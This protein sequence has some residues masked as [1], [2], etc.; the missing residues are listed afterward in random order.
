MNHFVRLSN[1]TSQ[2]NPPRVLAPPFFSGA[3]IGEF[4]SL[5]CLSLLMLGS[6]PSP[7]VVDLVAFS[8]MTFPFWGS[9]V[10]AFR[11]RA[12]WVARTSSVAKHAAANT[13]DFIWFFAS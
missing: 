13:L 10:G 8:S 1:R 4:G 9:P 11:D 12:D 6:T 3:A 7:R 2:R 5:V